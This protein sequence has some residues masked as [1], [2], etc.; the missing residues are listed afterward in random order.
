MLVQ[1]GFDLAK[2][3][4]SGAGAARRAAT[5]EASL[6]SPGRPTIGNGGWGAH[7]LPNLLQTEDYARALIAAAQRQ[8]PRQPP[9]AWPAGWNGSAAC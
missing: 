9:R 5:P 4:L 7:C 3:G 2:Q 6:T 8:A 1:G